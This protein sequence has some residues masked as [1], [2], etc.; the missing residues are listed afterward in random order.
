[1]KAASRKGFTLI[2]ILIV[3]IILGILAAIVIPQFTNA[4]QDAKKSSV[5]STVQSVRSQVGLYALQ[6]GDSAPDMT[7]AASFWGCLTGKTV[8]GGQTFGPYMQS[9]PVNPFNQ[10]TDV[11]FDTTLTA[12]KGW[13]FDGTKFFGYVSMNGADAQLIGD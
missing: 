11:Q 3:V 13:N 4:S 2:E 1:M 5:A 7:S 6:H 10:S 8:S 9:I 12:G